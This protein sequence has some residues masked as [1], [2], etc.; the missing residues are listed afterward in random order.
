MAIKNLNYKG[1]AGDFDPQISRGPPIYH[2]CY[3]ANVSKN[4]GLTFGEKH[5]KL[6]R[7]AE[8]LKR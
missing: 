7:L 6:A 4:L 2:M 1:M 5:F 3:I 8:R